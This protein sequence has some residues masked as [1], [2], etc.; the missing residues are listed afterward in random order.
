MS[1]QRAYI[2]D[3]VATMDFCEFP[4]LKRLHGALW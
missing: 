3:H 4:Q 2:H 1:D